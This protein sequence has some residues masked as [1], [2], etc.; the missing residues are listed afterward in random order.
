M[1]SVRSLYLPLEGLA[2][3]LDGKLLLALVARER[4]WR[5]LIGQRSAISARRAILPP[6]VFL[7]HSGRKRKS[8]LFERF[9]RLGHQSVVL[10]E[11]ALVRQTDEIFLMK[12]E[13]DAFDKVSLLLTWGEDDAEFW[14]NSQRIEPE[15]VVVTGNPRM[16]MARRD[17]RAFHQAEIAAIRERFGDYV[18]L[19][20]N[21]TTVNHFISGGSAL[22]FARSATEEQILEQKPAYLSH[23]QA[24]FER[25]QLLVPKIAQAIAPLTLVVR[26]HP[27]ER[28]EPWLDAVAG[29]PNASVVQEG[30]VVPWIT[31]AR[32]MVHNG[33]TSAVESA[34]TGTT[35]LSCRPV[36]SGLFDNPL[37]NGL[38]TECF[39]DDT[40]IRELQAVLAGGP[41]PL[42]P[43][44]S[45]L[46]ERHITGASGRLSCERI[47]DA[48]DQLPVA[49]E[50]QSKPGYFERFKRHAKLY[51]RVQS[52]RIRKMLD[53]RHRKR[54]AIIGRQFRELTPRYLDD[55]I[56]LFQQSLG[57]FHGRKAKRLAANLF[58]I[59]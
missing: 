14:R 32:V 55:R 19:N 5:P 45:S 39:D 18:L 50:G 9:D 23:K 29:S 26:P 21:F 36:Q 2:R 58:A 34:V 10:D 37:P 1:A 54:L 8:A 20:T 35:I 42:T 53:A 49:G 47:I 33:C 12:H 17:L 28:H 25:F 27:T 52:L 3:E 43:D 40:L 38:G 24:L 31:G 6:G 7:S 4:G 13:K 11:E 16:D 15:R 57:R 30:S 48:L 51:Q 46:L 22:H 59:E 41:R 56:G 44:Q